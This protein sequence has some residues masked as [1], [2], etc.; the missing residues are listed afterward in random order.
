M[1][2]AANRKDSGLP[3]AHLFSEFG[4]QFSYIIIPL[5]AARALNAS[6][7]QMGILMSVGAVSVLAAPFVGAAFDKNR[8][9]VAGM[10]VSDMARAILYFAIIMSFSYINMYFLVTLMLGITFFTISFDICRTSYVADNYK[11]P[12]NFNSLL[13]LITSAAEIIGPGAASLSLSSM[14][15]QASLGFVCVSFLLSAFFIL[16][17]KL[18]RASFYTCNYGQT[19]IDCKPYSDDKKSIGALSAAYYIIRNRDIFSFFVLAIGWSFCSRV[20]MSVFFISSVKNFG[21]TDYEVSLPVVIGG[22]GTILSALICRFFFGGRNLL[23]FNRGF[24]FCIFLAA[25]SLFFSDKIS[26]LSLF[27]LCCFMFL[28]FLGAGACRTSSLTYRQVNVNIDLLGKINSYFFIGT[29][30]SIPFGAMLGGVMYD[31]GGLEM[32]S[33]SSLLMFFVFLS[34]SFIDPEK[35]FFRSY[36]N[37]R[38]QEQ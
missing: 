32:V 36:L 33:V 37:S 13:L 27:L 38:D 16:Y 29:N 23:A 30:V 4:F 3:I 2:S 8:K 24:F 6:G 26:S 11:S 19:E 21:L 18:N 20:L 12:H 35:M 34:M 25:V 10:I 1:I 28:L 17:P 9:Y 15:Y 7:F 22:V 31:C 5:I 14:G